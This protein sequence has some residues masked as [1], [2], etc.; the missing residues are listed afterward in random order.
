MGQGSGFEWFSGPEGFVEEGFEDWE[1]DGYDSDYGFADSPCE[2]LVASLVENQVVGLPAID[3]QCWGIRP[4]C[5]NN[6]NDSCA[7][8]E[9][10]WTE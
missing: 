6:S 9:K 7:D 3:I 2:K 10:S 5:Q 4:K 1:V 8:D